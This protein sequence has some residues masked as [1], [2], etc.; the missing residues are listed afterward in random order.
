M[1]IHAI[2]WHFVQMFSQISHV[3]NLLGKFLVK[4]CS[5]SAGVFSNQSAKGFKLFFIILC[6]R[7]ISVDLEYKNV[8]SQGHFNTHSWKSIEKFKSVL[9]NL[10]FCSFLNRGQLKDVYRL[11]IYSFHTVLIQ[12]WNFM[13][14]N[15]AVCHSVFNKG[16]FVLGQK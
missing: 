3:P 6:H 4:R 11:E 15:F 16:I 5:L 14:G 1:L 8:T 13:R 10:C 12:M 9:F 7:S 2:S